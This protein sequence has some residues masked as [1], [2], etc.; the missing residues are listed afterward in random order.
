M[1]VSESLNQINKNFPACFSL[2]PPA[3]A[4]AVQSKEK[5]LLREKRRER[6][7]GLRGQ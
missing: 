4:K 1:P 5:D 2:C 3:V 7:D 6:W